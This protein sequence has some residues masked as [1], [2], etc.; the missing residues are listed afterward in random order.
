MEVGVGPVPG[1]V[2]SLGAA[3]GLTLL[4]AWGVPE[5]DAEDWDVPPTVALE[6]K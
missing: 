3:L 1:V 2:L 4:L 5:L 6:K